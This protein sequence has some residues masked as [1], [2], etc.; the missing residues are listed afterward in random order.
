M[1]V[2]RAEHQCFICQSMTDAESNVGLRFVGRGNGE[3]RVK[4]QGDDEWDDWDSD[5]DE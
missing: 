5:W 1:Y 3:A 2:M 4:G